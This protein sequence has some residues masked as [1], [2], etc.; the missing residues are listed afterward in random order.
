MQGS[1]KEHAYTVETS[2]LHRVESRKFK[3]STIHIRFVDVNRSLEV[4]MKKEDQRKSETSRLEF[5]SVPKSF[6]GSCMPLLQ[7]SIIVLVCSPWL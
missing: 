7:S 3:N 2:R 1:K 5:L 4:I 6:L